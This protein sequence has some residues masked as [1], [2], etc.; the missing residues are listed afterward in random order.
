VA[1]ARLTDGVRLATVLRGAA[2]RS[3]IAADI[4]V[5][6]TAELRSRL[7]D[8]TLVEA[9]AS[10]ARGTCVRRIDAES[11]AYRC[12]AE[13]G[14]DVA[15]ELARELGRGG[16]AQAKRP[17]RPRRLHGAAADEV[18]ALVRIVE[19]V[20]GAARAADDRVRQVVVEAE[21]R[22][23]RVTVATLEGSV[24]EDDRALLYLTIS[25]IARSGRRV[26]TGVLT[27]ATSGA[28]EELDAGAAGREAALRATVALEARQAPVRRL[29]VI[30]GPGRG[31]VL[32][33]EACCHPVE[34][35]EVLR[36]SIY[37]GRTGRS[38]ASP[39]V[40]IVDD[41]L[42]ADGAGS[43]VVDDDG[44]DASPTTVV[45]EGV[46][47]SF[48]TDRV[49]ALRL[50]V[51]STGNGRRLGYTHT[52]L[53]RMTNTCVRG[54]SAT[55]AEIIADTRL[56]IYAQHV[57]GGEVVESTGDFVF[58]VTNGFMIENGRLGDPIEETT[59]RGNGAVVLREIDAIA[60]DV[61]IG[62][63]KCAKLGQVLP[64][65]VV[66]PTLRIRSLLVGGTERG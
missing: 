58:R 3:W 45:E 24:A 35:D 1:G 38:I 16:A 43:I 27:P 15:G 37:A 34:G 39:L 25:V 60:N 46:L 57:G 23:Q 49:S 65:G 30:V 22:R 44:L 53:P 63:A 12:R 4:L 59:V 2:T 26:A 42:L 48:L 51:A 41:P 19:A 32:V 40:T 33:H 28:L 6:E 54:G 66:A 7:A 56:G 47:C 50:G 17:T 21:R 14:D 62:A 64:V 36:S 11:V 8:S 31:A 9:T 13:I 29:P 52:S 61:E 5:E 18:E 55:P 20:D 10:V